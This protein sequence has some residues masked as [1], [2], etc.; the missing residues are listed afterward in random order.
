ML[1]AFLAQICPD[2]RA[3]NPAMMRIVVLL[4][5]GTLLAACSASNR[6]E[7]IVPAWANTPPRPTPQYVARKN[8]LEGQSK[9]DA[10]PQAAPVQQ[11]AP[12]P[13][14]ARQETK[15]PAVGSLPEE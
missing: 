4:I 14:A 7:D 11:A 10:E 3:S 2:W 8:R 5:F 12:L 9:P 15:K 1:R 6:V 13:E